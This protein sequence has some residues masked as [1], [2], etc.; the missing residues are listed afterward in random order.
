[1]GRE[2]RRG[3]GELKSWQPHLVK[4]TGTAGVAACQRSELLLGAQQERFKL[5]ISSNFL[6]RRPVR[7]GVEGGRGVMGECSKGRSFFSLG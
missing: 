6:G 1:M 2:E 4:I 3:N 5:N 7:W